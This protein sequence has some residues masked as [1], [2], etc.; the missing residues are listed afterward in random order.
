[1]TT[2]L[3]FFFAEQFGGDQGEDSTCVL[4]ILCLKTVTS[5]LSKSF[6]HLTSNINLELIKLP[7]SKQRRDSHLYEGDEVL[8]SVLWWETVQYVF[9]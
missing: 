9:L 3:L 8:A 5:I 1:M 2:N 4:D 6:R 7:A